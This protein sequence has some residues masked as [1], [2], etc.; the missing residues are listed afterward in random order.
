MDANVARLGRILEDLSIRGNK[1]RIEMA[2]RRD[3]Q[4]VE[5]IGQ[6]RAWDRSGIHRHGRGQFGDADT[7]GAK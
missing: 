1:D 7:G 2:S 5:G 3:Q 6:R 4:A